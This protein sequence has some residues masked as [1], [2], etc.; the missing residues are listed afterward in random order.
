MLHKS[1][2]STRPLAKKLP[3]VAPYRAVFPTSS[4][5]VRSRIRRSVRRQRMRMSAPDTSSRM[6]SCDTEDNVVARGEGVLLGGA[7]HNLAAVHT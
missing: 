1:G 3:P 5:H 4:A 6:R 7:D 2:H